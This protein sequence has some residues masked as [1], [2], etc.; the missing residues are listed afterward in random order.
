[1]ARYGFGQVQEGG[2]WQPILDTL[3]SYAWGLISRPQTLPAQNI[4][5]PTVERARTFGPQV[6][7]PRPVSPRGGAARSAVPV[8]GEESN[9]YEGTFIPTV[10]PGQVGR[11][12]PP[13]RVTP[14]QARAIEAARGGRQSPIFDTPSPLPRPAPSAPVV[15]P[16]PVKVD[17]REPGVLDVPRESDPGA[18]DETT[19]FA[20]K[21]PAPRAIPLPD[22]GA[23][24]RAIPTLP[25]IEGGLEMAIPWGSIGRNV[26]LPAIGGYIGTEIAESNNQPREVVVDT[27]T[28]EVKRCRRRRRRRLLTPTDLADLAS[29]QTLVGKGSDAMKFAVTKAVRR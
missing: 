5:S 1:M 25:T 15:V 7:V 20:G 4:G 29:L 8:A 16:R 21:I 12:P 27:R 22:L 19:V 3:E 14:A 24:A 18:T 26:V 6:D 10:R 17:P 11:R 13:L 9:G 2:V 23:A 28:G